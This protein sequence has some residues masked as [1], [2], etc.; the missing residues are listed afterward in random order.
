MCR[1]KVA[2]YVLN[3]EFI[4]FYHMNMA[5]YVVFFPYGLY[6]LLVAVC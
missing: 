2:K 4:I 6:L 5:E 1:C 3:N